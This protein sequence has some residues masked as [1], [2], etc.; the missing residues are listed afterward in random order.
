NA[1]G[2]FRIGCDYAKMAPDDPIVYPSV[3]G[4]SHL[5]TFFGNVDVSAYSTNDS[6]RTSGNT[7]CAGGIANRSGY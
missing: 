1:G 4:A 2:E 5:H 7:T 6:L 3:P